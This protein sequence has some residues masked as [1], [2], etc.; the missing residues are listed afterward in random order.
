[1]HSSV[2]LKS[3]EDLWY[4]FVAL[5]TAL[6]MQRR[7]SVV[8]VRQKIA[9]TE[10]VLFVPTRELR[11]L[12]KQYKDVMADEMLDNSPVFCLSCRREMVWCNEAT[13]NLLRILISI[14]DAQPKILEGLDKTS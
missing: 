12:A 11:F 1:M 5:A 9:N 13:E 14:I 4:V 6:S 8:P 3:N 10:R 7:T 2:Q